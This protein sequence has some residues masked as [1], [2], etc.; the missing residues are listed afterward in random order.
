MQ[1]LT[2]VETNV[3]MREDIPPDGGYG[4]PRPTTCMFISFRLTSSLS[5]AG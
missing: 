3:A 1:T 4:K 5:Q 2:G